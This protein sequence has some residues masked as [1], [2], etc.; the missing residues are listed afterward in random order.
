MDPRKVPK[1]EGNPL[2]LRVLRLRG[3]VKANM[4]RYASP[5]VLTPEDLYLTEVVTRADHHPR[6][7]SKLDLPSTVTRAQWCSIEVR[8]PLTFDLTD[9]LL[10]L[11]LCERFDLTLCDLLRER[12]DDLSDAAEV[13]DV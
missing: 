9:E 7:E 3:L 6:I 8:E 5:P 2:T 10:T 13:R 12:S 1:Q 4:E 11:F